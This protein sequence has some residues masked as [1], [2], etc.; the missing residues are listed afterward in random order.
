MEYNS[1]VVTPRQHGNQLRQ[2]M[3]A[4]PDGAQLHQ[5]ADI[6]QSNRGPQDIW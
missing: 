1:A 3:Q 2:E 4:L 5:R 6:P